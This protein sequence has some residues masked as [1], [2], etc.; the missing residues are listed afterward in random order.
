MD[1]R[2]ID[3]FSFGFFADEGL[4]LAQRVGRALVEGA[5][6]VPITFGERIM[7]TVTAAMPDGGAWFTFSQ[8]LSYKHEQTEALTAKYPEHA[9]TLREYADRFL[10]FTQAGA[11][12]ETPEHLP[13]AETKAEWGG[14]G[15]D[16]P[17][18]TSA[19][20]S[21]SARTACAP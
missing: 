5:K 18:Q 15:A 8:G 13:L 1:I 17:T 2:Q 7:P 6:Y 11:R 14:A 12:P 20:L 9:E 16:T 3:P 19:A 10:P 21:T 4:E